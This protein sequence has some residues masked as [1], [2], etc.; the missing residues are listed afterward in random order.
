[1]SHV[2]LLLQEAQQNL[3]HLLLRVHHVRAAPT[4]TPADNLHRRGALLGGCLRRIGWESRPGERA[5]PLAL[6]PLDA[7]QPCLLQLKV[8]GCQLQLLLVEL[9][10]ALLQDREDRV[11]L[12]QMDTR[13]F[14]QQRQFQRFPVERH[15]LGRDRRW[16]A[17]KRLGNRPNR[18]DRL[19]AGKGQGMGTVPR[20]C[21]Q[22]TTTGHLGMAVEHVPCCCSPPGCAGRGSAQPRA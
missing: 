8:C 22:L 18:L 6:Q 21:E 9:T 12:C 15:E 11:A 16:R 1:M 4:V 19:D 17:A 13:V 14:L 3:V 2:P 20:W 5:R 10:L 7:L